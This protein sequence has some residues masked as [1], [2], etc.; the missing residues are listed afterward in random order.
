MKKLSIL[1]SALSCLTISGCSNGKP[2]YD[3][4]VEDYFEILQE[5][6]GNRYREGNIVD[7]YLKYKEEGSPVSVRLNGEIWAPRF[8]DINMGYALVS[9]RMPG[10]NS[11]LQTTIDGCFKE[12]CPDGE[13]QFERKHY[14][15]ISGD[16]DHDYMEC[17]ICGYVYVIKEG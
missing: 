17:Q 3:L 11:T 14:H 7:V 9:F 16:H 13:H 6:M 4:V 12:K 5:E 2:I 8:Y 1:L 15:S 10:F